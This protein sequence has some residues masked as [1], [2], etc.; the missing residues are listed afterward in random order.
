MEGGMNRTP[1][2]LFHQSIHAVIQETRAPAR[3]FRF[4]VRARFEFDVAA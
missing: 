2:A 3:R 4:E 1:A